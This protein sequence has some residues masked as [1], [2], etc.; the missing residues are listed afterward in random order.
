MNGLNWLAR[1]YF[2]SVT[3]ESS[4]C[5]DG[6]FEEMFLGHDA[7]GFT[8]NTLPFDLEGIVKLLRLRVL[9]VGASTQTSGA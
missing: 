6:A 2:N 7:S 3:N 8:M 5:Q 9:G 1:G 4:V